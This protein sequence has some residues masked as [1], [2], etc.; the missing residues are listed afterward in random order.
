M[1]K[2]KEILKKTRQSRILK[3]KGE[4]AHR[5]D[6]QTSSVLIPKLL[7][8]QEVKAALGQLEG[9]TQQEGKLH[10]QFR[11]SSFERALGFLSGLALKARAVGHYPQ[12][13]N[14]YNCVT[15]DLTTPEAGGITN[16]DVELAHKANNLA[17]LLN[18]PS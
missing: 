7:S 16:L 14:L 12:K 5:G 10:R 13:S 18:S 8:S 2:C 17:S 6:A 9:W 1:V 11:F 3:R 4:I 15:V